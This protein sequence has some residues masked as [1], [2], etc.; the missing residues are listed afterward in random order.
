M[1]NKMF[2]IDLNQSDRPTWLVYSLRDCYGVMQYVGVCQFANLL[3]IPDA[4]KH[5]L[6]AKFFPEASIVT[7]EILEMSN[8]RQKC[9]LWR[10]NYLLRKPR[11]PMLQYFGSYR[12]RVAVKCIETNEVFYSLTECA[13]AH[14]V[15]ASNLSKH[16]KGDHCYRFVGGRQYK[17]AMYEKTDKGGYSPY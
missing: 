14:G 13:T 16:L 8:T 7:V 11:P 10:A 17:Y 4:R 9:N 2:S 6:F 3:C 1:I 15:S 12:G 5:P